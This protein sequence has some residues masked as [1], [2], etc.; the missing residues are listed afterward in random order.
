MRVV[1]MCIK[2][3]VAAG[4]RVHPG[5]DDVCVHVSACVCMPGV[6]AA[7]T[8]VAARGGEHTGQSG[9]SLCSCASH[10]F[11]IASNH[12]TLARPASAPAFPHPKPYMYP[13]SK[14][15]TSIDSTSLPL[16]APSVILGLKLNQPTTHVPIV[17][18]G[19]DHR[20]HLCQQ[21][22][23]TLHILSQQTKCINQQIHRA[24]CA[25]SG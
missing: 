22:P 1:H 23:H 13:H 17:P 24:C 14:H 7:A 9:V 8:R 2:M 16:L 15:N 12:A 5:Q 20:H 3:H 10:S 25:C 19:A 18:T 6:G 4:G 21:R 11:C